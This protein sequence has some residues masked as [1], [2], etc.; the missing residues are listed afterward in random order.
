[1][2]KRATTEVV[3]STRDFALLQNT[4]LSAASHH[5]RVLEKRGETVR[6]TRGI[7]ANPHHPH[8]TLM[9]CVSFLLG[10]EQGYVS[11]LTALHRHGMIS[12]IPPV[13]QVATTG[14]S[15]KLETSIGRFEFFQLKPSMMLP[16]V[17]WSDSHIPY[18]MA[19]L[20]K[21]LM[22]TFY[23]ATRKGRRFIKLP[24]MHL[25]FNRKKLLKLIKEQR[26]A[27]PMRQAILRR[28]QNATTHEAIT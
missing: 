27:L 25:E 13:I 2:A 21:A 18:R 19:S 10:Q 3:F 4:S 7:W 20:E 15:R 5:L 9:A 8:F 24:E 23:I 17:E 14:H 12:Q 26:F 22:D 16:G 28:I 1:M 11:F 6:I